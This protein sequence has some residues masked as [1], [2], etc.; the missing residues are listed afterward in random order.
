MA[1]SRNE[2]ARDLESK[3]NCALLHP[4]RHSET[5]D[6]NLLFYQLRIPAKANPDSEGNANGIPGRRRKVSERRDA[7][8]S[9][10]QEVFV[11]VKKNLS[12]AQRRTPPEAEK[13]VRGKGRQPFSPPQ[14]SA[15]QASVSS[16]AARCQ[17]AESQFGLRWKARRD[18]ADQD[19]SQKRSQQ[20]IDN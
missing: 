20:V 13:G 11:F 3:T 2:R 19:R 14:L 8:I 7:G 9:I 5:S 4:S 10:V 16:T 15:T 1:R 18:D 17:R 6:A 12:G